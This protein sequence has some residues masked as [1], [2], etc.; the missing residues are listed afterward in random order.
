M[1]TFPGSGAKVPVSTKGGLRPKWRADGKELFYITPEGK[2]MAV[3]IRGGSTFE[4][5]VP[6]LLFDVAN[7]RSLTGTP[8]DVAPD[9]QRFLFLSGRVDANPS[10]IAV[11]L[12]WTSDLKK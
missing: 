7:A 2:L 12:N 6:N 9:G 8:Y 5:G 11:V 4:A 1:Q 10:S 3:E